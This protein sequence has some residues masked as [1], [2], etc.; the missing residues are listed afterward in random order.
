MQFILILS[1]LVAVCW[2]QNTTATISQ[3]TKGASS[4]MHKKDLST[5]GVNLLVPGDVEF[6]AAAD[7]VLL[8]RG[9][10]LAPAVKRV[11]V[12][13][14]N[15]SDKHIIGYA[16]LWHFVQQDGKIIDKQATFVQPASLGDG[17]RTEK[18]L[19]HPASGS[20][21]PRSERLISTIGSIGSKTSLDEFR[22]IQIQQQVDAF[23][24]L[25]GQSREV[26]VTLDGIFFEDGSFIG[27]NHTGFFEAVVKTFDAVQDFNRHVLKL[28]SEHVADAEIVNWVKEQKNKSAAVSDMSRAEV[29]AA[30]NEFLAIA[31]HSGIPTAI[32]VIQDKTFSL[33]PGFVNRGE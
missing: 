28:A 29:F 32:Q 8:H 20:I 12:V 14:E 5:H 17:T 11:S 31:D 18:F 13:I 19:D 7:R 16:V 21:S 24:G 3:E 4:P 23:A 33:R 22:N 30:A 15:R 10:D 1:L 25:I 27:P 9:G 2:G 6:E 26:N